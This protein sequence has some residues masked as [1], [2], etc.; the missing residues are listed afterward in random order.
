VEFGLFPSPAPCQACELLLRLQVP[1][2]PKAPRQSEVSHSLPGSWSPL[3]DR[4]HSPH[5]VVII[6]ALVCLLLD[7]SSWRVGLYS[8]ISLS[9]RSFGPS[10]W[11]CWVRMDSERANKSQ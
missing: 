3:Q 6:R 4:E 8:F 2:F 10:A 1:A 7:G 9:L 5:C 11:L